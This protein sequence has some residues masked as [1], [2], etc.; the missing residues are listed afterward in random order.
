MRLAMT[1][2]EPLAREVREVEALVASVNR[3]RLQDDEGEQ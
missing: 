2:P 1:I 3:R